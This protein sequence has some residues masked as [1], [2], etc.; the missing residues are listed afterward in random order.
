MSEIKYLWEF[1]LKDGKTVH[2]RFTDTEIN[3]LKTKY[4]EIS[5]TT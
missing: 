5:W 4:P 1:L 2:A 3:E